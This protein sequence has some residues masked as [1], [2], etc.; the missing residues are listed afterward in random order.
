MT[1]QERK[2]FELALG[3]LEAALSDDKQVV[4]IVEAKLKEKNG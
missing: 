3:A 1:P 4:R 2:V